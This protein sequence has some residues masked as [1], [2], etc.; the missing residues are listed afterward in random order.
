MSGKYTFILAGNGSYSNKGCEA[1]TRGTVECLR[2]SFNDPHIIAV[3]AYKYEGQFIEQGENEYDTR[4]VHKKMVA[5]SKRFQPV[6]W[7]NSVLRILAP[8]L[9]K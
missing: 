7:I 9:T 6:W 4:I 5:A 3:S 2:G 1:I 8:R